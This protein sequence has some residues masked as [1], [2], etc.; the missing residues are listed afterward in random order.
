MP[1]DAEMFQYRLPSEHEAAEVFRGLTNMAMAGAAESGSV[2]GFE[3]IRISDGSRVAVNV[4]L[5]PRVYPE[6]HRD[7]AMR[8]AWQLLIEAG[9]EPPNMA[10]GRFMSEIE[11]QALL[12]VVTHCLPPGLSAAAQAVLDAAGVPAPGSVTGI[13]TGAVKE[14]I[15]AVDATQDEILQAVSDVVKVGIEKYRAAKADGVVTT[16]EKIAIAQSIIEVALKDVLAD[17]IPNLDQIIS[18]VSA[19][20]DVAMKVAIKSPAPKP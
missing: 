3:A 1:T 16:Q 7:H 18:V 2:F 20:I 12:Y 13:L 6:Q 15:M 5:T 9:V 10:L 11:K 19:V 4:R 8:Q 17:D 14:T